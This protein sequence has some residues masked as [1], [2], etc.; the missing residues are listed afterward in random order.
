[1]H[2]TKNNPLFF[3]AATQPRRSLRAF[4]SR[5][6]PLRDSPMSPQPPRLSR[7]A[8]DATNIVTRRDHTN[9]MP[10]N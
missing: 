2:H 5:Y 10:P 8:T 7:L 3:H 9:A 1:M 6:S 4:T